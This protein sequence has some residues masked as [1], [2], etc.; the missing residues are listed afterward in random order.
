MTIAPKP[1]R[2]I[3]EEIGD[4]TKC[5]KQQADR[6]PLPYIV[7]RGPVGEYFPDIFLFCDS[8]HVLDYEYNPAFSGDRLIMKNTVIDCKTFDDKFVHLFTQKVPSFLRASYEAAQNFYVLDF[9]YGV[10]VAARRILEA[11][12]MDNVATL[13]CMGKGFTAPFNVAIPKEK[14]EIDRIKRDFKMTVA[15]KILGRVGR[16]QTDNA[17]LRQKLESALEE[18]PVLNLG[19]D[20]FRNLSDT[21]YHLSSSVHGSQIGSNNAFNVHFRNIMDAIDQ[22][23]AKKGEW[24]VIYD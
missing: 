1:Y 17:R 12:I 15:L 5:Y 14:A 18:Y 8:R 3:L 20:V 24:Y 16:W 9:E 11:F 13:S 2:G 10:S 22:Y 21:Y 23:Y 7:R 4:V 6:L 19:T